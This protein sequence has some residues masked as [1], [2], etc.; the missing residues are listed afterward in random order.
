MNKAKFFTFL[1]VFLIIALILFM[2]FMVFWLK[3]E[4]SQCAR[5]PIGYFENKNSDI[6]CTCIEYGK[7]FGNIQINSQ[8]KSGE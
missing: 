5:D 2:I 6:Y 8:F 3:E 4:G 1:Y 7:G